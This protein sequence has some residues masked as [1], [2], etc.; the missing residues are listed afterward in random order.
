[1]LCTQPSLKM[2]K[3]STHYKVI[4]HCVSVWYAPWPTAQFRL[5]G[6]GA[7]LSERLVDWV[8]VGGVGVCWWYGWLIECLAVWLVD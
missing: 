5:L 6:C 8:F 4:A 2:L 1:M 3:T 7:G